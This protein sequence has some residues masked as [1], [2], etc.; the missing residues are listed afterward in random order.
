MSHQWPHGDLAQTGF[1]TVTVTSCLAPSSHPRLGGA[2]PRPRDPSTLSK[3]ARAVSM[4]LGH[5]VLAECLLEETSYRI[6][7]RSQ[8]EHTK[9][10]LSRREA[11]SVS[12]LTCLFPPTRV[13]YCK[14][15]KV[16]GH[17]V[18]RLGA[19]KLWQLPVAVTV[20]PTDSPTQH[21][22]VALHLQGWM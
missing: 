19:Q 22:G 7:R 20:P 6:W 17:S 3:K 8:R 2:S 13:S 21:L 5:L 12:L 11:R 4:G 16:L 9:V 1:P 15:D 14:T 18:C 10:A